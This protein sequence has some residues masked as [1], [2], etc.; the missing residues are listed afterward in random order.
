MY[1]YALRTIEALKD[2]FPLRDVRLVIHEP[3]D[4]NSKPQKSG[5]SN[6]GKQGI[7]ATTAVYTLGG[8]MKLTPRHLSTIEEL[9]REPWFY[10]PYN[11]PPAPSPSLSSSSTSTSSSHSNEEST[12]RESA[13]N[14]FKVGHLPVSARKE[15]S[16]HH[17]SH[18]HRNK[19]MDAQM[20]GD[21]YFTWPYFDCREFRLQEQ[22][23]QQQLL[24]NSRSN[25]YHRRQQRQDLYFTR[26]DQGSQQRAEELVRRGSNSEGNVHLHHDNINNNLK[27]NAHD[28]NVNR[29]YT[30]LASYTAWFP[31]GGLNQNKR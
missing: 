30:W 28:E 6:P 7:P 23:Q 20:F 25:Y 21:S 5:G 8:D 10:Y 14:F 3:D 18:Y 1:T 2:D 26:V 29:T 31:I 24:R 19:M 11:N 17:R 9:R 13:K 22:Q 27:G 16:N 4:A 15:S 12:V